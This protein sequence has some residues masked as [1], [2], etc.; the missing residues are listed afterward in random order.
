MQCQICSPPFFGL[1]CYRTVPQIW[2][3]A[4]FC[5]HQWT[6]KI[7]PAA[8]GLVNNVM[9]GETLDGNSGTR[10]PS[11]YSV[12]EHCPAWRGELGLEPNFT[13]YISHLVQIFT[14]VKRVLKPDGVCFVNLG[15]SYAGSGKGIGSIDPKWTRARTDNNKHKTDWSQISVPAKSLMNIPHRF[16]I[17][18]TDDLQMIQRNNLNW[19]KPACMPSSAKDRW[20]VDF[21]SIGFFSKNGEYKFNQDLE[22]AVQG[23]SG[24]TFTNGKTADATIRPI[25]TA[26]RTV[27]DEIRNARTTW[28]INYEPSGESHYASY[29]TKLAEKMILAGTDPGDTVLDIFNGT[30][31]TGHAAIRNRRKYIGIELQPDY[32]A[33]SEKRLAEVQVKLFS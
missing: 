20:T 6:D 13:L 16:F 8:N 29:P 2:D 15:D 10:S 19:L 18:M 17:A 4:E 5:D 12:C 9:Q 26:E 24:S 22:P 28:K 30:A 23:W 3:A 31:S 33:I 1:R 11:T 27:N 21:E 14:E 25:G 7:K 32:I